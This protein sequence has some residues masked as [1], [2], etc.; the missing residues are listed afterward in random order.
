MAEPSRRRETKVGVRVGGGPPPGYEWNVTILDVAYKEA[1]EFLDGDQYTHIAR[2]VK[3]LA[4]QGDPTHSETVDV[5]AIENY[6]EIRDKGG[7]L[8]RLNVRV[9]FYVHDSNRTIVVLGTIK[10]EADGTTPMAIK[11]RMRHRIRQY[12]SGLGNVDGS[13]EGT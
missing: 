3:E 10:K 5:K 13:V 9:F 8:G 7:I 1:M 2:Q 6:C 11:I 12:L 4:Q